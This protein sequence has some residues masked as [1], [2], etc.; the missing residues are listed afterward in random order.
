MYLQNARREFIT[1]SSWNTLRTESNLNRAIKYEAKANA[2]TARASA[3]SA[4]GT[5][6]GRV[7]SA[8]NSAKARGYQSKADSYLNKAMDAETDNS[9]LAG[10][11]GRGILTQA[12]RLGTLTAVSKGAGGIVSGIAQKAGASEETAEFAG[13]VA[14]A[15][16]AAGLTVNTAKSALT[17]K[18]SAIDGILGLLKNA[19]EFLA[20]KFKT[21]AALKGAASKIDDIFSKIMN[22]LSPARFTDDIIKKI[23]AK[24]GI[25]IGKQT[26]AALSM[27]IGIA[28]GGIVGAISGA[29][30]VEHL[31][32]VLPGDADALMTTIS[33]AMKGVF[34]ALEMI[35]GIGCAVLVLDIVDPI[36]QAVLK[37]GLKSFIARNLYKALGGDLDTLDAKFNAEREYYN[38]KY[39]TNIDTA[40]MND[41]INRTGIIDTVWH[42]K[43]QYDEDGHLKFDAAGGTI[44]NGL[45]QL[46][47]GGEKD[48]AKDE[49]GNVIR[50][51]DGTAVVQKDAYGATVK[52]DEKWGDKVGKAFN[53]VGH[54][55]TGGD[56]DK[57][58]EKGSSL[59]DSVTGEYIVDH[60]E[61]N[62]FGK[63][64]D[65]LSAA[66]K[67]IVSA[68][69]A[70]GSAVVNTVKAAG[71]G[72]KNLGSAALDKARSAGS[73]VL[74]AG[75][76]AGSVISGGLSKIG[77]WLGFGGGDKE[78]AATKNEAE[79][80]KAENNKQVINVINTAKKVSG[81]ILSFL[82]NPVETT[83]KAVEKINE[84]DEEY[85]ENGNIITKGTATIKNVLKKG[86]GTITSIFKKP[87]EEA[88]E[89]AKESEKSDTPRL[90]SD[91][92][93]QYDK[94]S[95][96]KSTGIGGLLTSALKG[97]KS[98]LMKPAEEVADM[99]REENGEKYEK[100]ANGNVIADLSNGATS[101]TGSPLKK[102]NFGN[103]IKTG[104]GKLASFIT[105]P[106]NDMIKS[107]EEWDN[108][109]SP[110]AT[111]RSTRTG[112][113]SSSKSPFSWIKTKISNLWGNITS[114]I[115]NASSSNRTSTN[116]SSYVGGGIGA[117]DDSSS[118]DALSPLGFSTS[119][120][121]S[122]G[123][124][125][126]K[127][128]RVTSA[129][130]NR[131]LGSGS[132]FHKGIDIVPQDGS[133]KADISAR[134]AGRVVAIEKNI[135]DSHTGLNVSS[136]TTGNY[137]TIETPDGQNRIKYFHMKAGS[138]P[139]G[140]TTG[141]NINVGDKIGSMGSTG[142]STGPHLH[143]QLEKKDSSGN[144]QTYDPY[145]DISGSG[146]NG[147]AI[148]STSDF[149]LT[150]DS[151]SSD[152]SSSSGP[153]GQLITK[154]KSLG[155]EFLAKV[156]GGLFGAD[157]D[158]AGDS[159]SSDGG[160]SV[161]QFLAMC[162]AEIGTAED[163][164][165]SN[166]VKYNTWYYGHEVSGAAYPWCMAF[167]QWCFNNAGLTLEHK[168]ASCADMLSWYKSNHPDMVHDT[169]EKG[170]IMIQSGH[171]GIVESVNG[172]SVGTIEGNTSNAVARRTQSMSSIIGFIRPVDWSSLG[173][174]GNFGN[175]DTSIG[176]LWNY[177]KSIGF[178]DFGA[179][180][181][182]GCWE[183][184][185]A[186]NPKRVEGDYLNI[187]KSTFGT[188]DQ[189]YIKAGND[190]ALLDSYTVKLFGKYNGGINQSAYEGGDGHKYPGL[191]Y[192]Q[193]TGPRGKTLL[194]TAKKSNT[195]WFNPAYQLSFANMEMTDP[196]NYRGPNGTDP[197]GKLAKVTSP[198]EAADTFCYYYEGI[199]GDQKRRNSARKL[200][201]T[202]AGKG[203]PIDDP[204]D[205]LSPYVGG[206]VA[207]DIDLSAGVGGPI[208]KDA[209][210]FKAAKRT[211]L[212]E[213]RASDLALRNAAGI[214]RQQIGRQKPVQ[215]IGG[216]I[217]TTQSSS[218]TTVTS[219]RQKSTV[220]DRTI[221]TP[222]QVI[223]LEGIGGA[224]IAPNDGDMARVMQLLSQAVA[225]LRSIS[226]NTG[227]S[228]SYL[229][230]INGKEFVDQGVR[231]TLNALG[232]SKAKATK[233]PSGGSSRTAT[234]LARP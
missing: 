56:V 7:S 120:A 46:F 6:R 75:K 132:E 29:C 72:L 138:I 99:I 39:G 55:F 206:S 31:F 219:P 62:I 117:P 133:G 107:A 118:S 54:F 148:N 58:E 77:S 89:F 198:E 103:F 158:G 81:G 8:Y 169:P 23:G 124:P 24:L 60:T 119:S 94:Q 79:K 212:R 149:S 211:F 170:D 128:F 27:G 129:Y 43:Q 134:Y 69:K 193:W 9:S 220:A 131:N 45:Q 111:D 141:S 121:V 18:K 154:L 209:V 177:A 100:D 38:Q 218:Y 113:S 200:Y 221:P 90:T 130:G 85:D 68:G 166:N 174:I 184:E 13:N 146:A 21:V 106:F 82:K 76:A 135:P 164:D 59:G 203:G 187:F 159:S 108:K 231:D 19:F 105:K 51:A 115:T 67:G 93:I 83:K 155:A 3:A 109:E 140:I 84:G 199:K 127:P 92:H 116:S 215:G 5:L 1:G 20:G 225:Y 32:G 223:S 30:S 61:K 126:T 163:P 50:S 156:T 73:A 197:K 186:N 161:D 190:R 232:S 91:G 74:N 227:D 228:V 41:L 191:G 4:S 114:S 101:T 26:A 33:S 226:A 234:Q 37:H 188:G 210:K 36:V 47:V 80:V 102:G 208:N 44:S 224:G 145:P 233:A 65:A 183:N 192:A 171:T 125:L 48:Y 104:L 143:Y 172:D 214:A 70:A 34:G 181:V 15:G 202:Y 64:G 167:V 112:S 230:A 185:S 63:T 49:N 97:V 96:S 137:V 42:G 175:V 182:L 52:V 178:N 17:G 151:S 217:E 152:N 229:D 147:S 86:I 207:E 160:Y 98:V 153:L 78:D 16:V 88:E 196:S 35:P 139:S 144:F 194:E 168:S 40:T 28:V 157:G 12:A 179:A 189:A 173:S 162:A 25:N 110:W 165:G 180:G 150:D 14:E 2:A 66:G 204:M 142:R 71:T 136:R 205:A 95:S 123:N 213:N 22:A 11:T 57:V 53:R 87:A 222:R 195:Q 216:P 176:G 201:D 10:S 122:G